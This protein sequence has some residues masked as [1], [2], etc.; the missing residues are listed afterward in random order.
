MNR[1][2]T[3]TN[4]INSYVQSH[5]TNITALSKKLDLKSRN[6]LQ[7]VSDGTA[8]RDALLKV[9]YAIQQYKEDLALSA[10]DLTSLAFIEKK[11][12]EGESY[13]KTF[14]FLNKIFF[15]VNGDPIKTR[16]LGTLSDLCLESIN[17]DHLKI[18]DCIVINACFPS[19]ISL[20]REIMEN[21][22]PEDPAND[23]LRVRHY[24]VRDSNPVTY[25]QDITSV[26]PLILDP[27]YSVYF[28][29]KDSV[30]PLS[31]SSNSILLRFENGQQIFI[32]FESENVCLTVRDDQIYEKYCG[33]L[34]EAKDSFDCFN[35]V[36]LDQAS[37]NLLKIYEIATNDEKDLDTSM[38]FPDFCL[39]FFSADIAGDI[40]TRTAN[41][42]SLDIPEGFVEALTQAHD[43]RRNCYF[44]GSHVRTVIITRN[45]FERFLHTGAMVESDNLLLPVTVTE[46]IRV[47]SRIYEQLQTQPFFKIY[48]AEDTGIFKELPFS[49]CIYGTEKIRIV[50]ALPQI[51]SLSF[52]KTI[53]ITDSDFIDAF[54]DFYDSELVAHHTCSAARTDEI[55]KNAF[56]YL[57]GELDKEI[58]AANTK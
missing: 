26:F 19:T 15:P 29:K 33:L 4:W 28:N 39:N 11:L 44:D 57:A 46:R 20:L 47:L 48:F 12:I 56:V 1:E 16:I 13:G 24:I 34:D 45:G 49:F 10:E 52:Q 27:L 54:A 43:Y 55:F 22:R 18:R 50:P 2:E 21:N 31:R 42:T 25:I 23:G 36:I 40:F 5:G 58:T 9:L 17:P 51:D 6:S 7:R 30:V 35:D 38:V 14:E 32:L 53:E 41:A 37:G 8:G 3:L